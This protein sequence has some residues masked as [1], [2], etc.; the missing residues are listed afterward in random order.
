MVCVYTKGDIPVL[1]NNWCHVHFDNLYTEV[2]D[3]EEVGC[4]GIHAHSWDLK[5]TC[6]ITFDFHSEKKLDNFIQ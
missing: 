2:V 4:L 5:Y 6:T 3:P 1:K